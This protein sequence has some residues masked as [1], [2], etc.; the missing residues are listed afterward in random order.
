MS[1]LEAAIR[2]ALRATRAL[3]I[4]P[5]IVEPRGGPEMESPDEL[6][7]VKIHAI[8][9]SR[10]RA[11]R[12][13]P[14]AKGASAG[15]ATARIWAIAGPA[16]EVPH[17]GA[18]AVL[19]L[20]SLAVKASRSTWEALVAEGGRVEAALRRRLTAVAGSISIPTFGLPALTGQPLPPDDVQD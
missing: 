8:S 18:R 7:E 13:A 9:L 3:R 6:R 15:T 20:S 16:L 2:M 12:R 17:Q 19:G 10:P 14:T 5:G 11:K 1:K 4:N